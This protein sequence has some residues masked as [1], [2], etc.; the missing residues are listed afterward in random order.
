MERIPNWQTYSTMSSREKASLA[1]EISALTGMRWKGMAQFSRWGI[2]LETSLFQQDGAE[3]VFLPGKD[4]E[5]GWSGLPNGSDEK[6][7]QFLAALEEDVKEYWNGQY[8]PAEI[9][10]LLTSPRR[11]VYLPPML[12]ER[13]PHAFDNSREISLDDLA[14]TEDGKKAIGQ[15][16]SNSRSRCMIFDSFEPG[17]PKLK[18]TRTKSGG[19]SAE[20]LQPASRD[21]LQKHLEES[22]FTL[23]DGDIWEYL[24]GGENGALFPWGNRLPDARELSWAGSKNGYG[25]T[26]GYDQNGY[27]RE[28]I[29]NCTWPFRGGDGGELACYGRLPALEPLVGSA[30][31]LGWYGRK[32]DECKEEIEMVLADGLCGEYDYYR[33]IRLLA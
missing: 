24:C 22:N 5:L 32:C 6:E 10:S 9:L 1:E 16:Q 12:V 2:E 14:Q 25:L 33:R 18:L 21:D 30:H 8:Q 29:K 19:I 26:I 28:V 15:F 4:T 3:F 20:I 27:H 7:K 31:F 11:K 17:N 23:P 13:V